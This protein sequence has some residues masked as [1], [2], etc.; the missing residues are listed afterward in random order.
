[1]C[2]VK[3]MIT[4]KSIYGSASQ[5]Q[6]DKLHASNGERKHIKTEEVKKQR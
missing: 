3:V 6:R 1:M 5:Q 4:M 2:D